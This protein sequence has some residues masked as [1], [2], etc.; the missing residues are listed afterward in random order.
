MSVL[1]RTRMRS[2]AD[3]FRRVSCNSK[4]FETRFDGTTVD[5][6]YGM[7]G[8]LTSIA[9]LDE[10]LSFSYD[11]D[12]L[13]LSASNLAGAVSSS[14]DSSTGWLD[15][16]IGADGTTVSYSRRNGGASLL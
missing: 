2:H 10:T 11:G 16:S 1:M 15:S 3:C 8:N 12:G 14:Y 7:D 5:Y 6:G 9:Y 13:M 4:A